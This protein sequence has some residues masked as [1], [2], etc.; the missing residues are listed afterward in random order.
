MT[1]PPRRVVADQTTFLAVSTVD[2][3]DRFNIVA[4]TEAHAKYELLDK[5]GYVVELAG[6]ESFSGFNLLDVDT[7]E[8]ECLLKATTYEA[9]LDE[10]LALAKWKIQ[11]STDMIGGALGSG[12]GDADD[13]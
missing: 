9:A 7:M 5:I 1:L 6:M 2:S 10:A 12:F 4:D 3:S 13:Q 8:V 11:G